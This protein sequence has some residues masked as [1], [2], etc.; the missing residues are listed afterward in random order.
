[1][2][3]SHFGLE[4]VRLWTR[5]REVRMDVDVHVVPRF[6][7]NLLALFPFQKLLLV[8]KRTHSRCCRVRSPPT[9][10]ERT[11]ASQREGG[12]GSTPVLVGW[13]HCHACQGNDV[14]KTEGD[15]DDDDDVGGRDEHQQCCGGCLWPYLSLTHGSRC[16]IRST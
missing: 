12:P 2:T 3:A 7:A 8:Y 14:F 11:W 16:Q 5:R 9:C 4:L 10:P 1:M 13:H 15:G 6:Y